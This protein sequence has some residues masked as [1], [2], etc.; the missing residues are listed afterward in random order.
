MVFNELQLPFVLKLYHAHI[1][2]HFCF[3]YNSYNTFQYRKHPFI[4]NYT[5]NLLHTIF[6]I[7]LF[8][9]KK[10]FL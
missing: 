10:K 4:H 9:N 3:N 8:K 5:Y 7:N 1:H 6:N 2:K